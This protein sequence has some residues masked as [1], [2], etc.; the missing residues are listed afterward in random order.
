MIGI[1]DS[2]VGGLTAYREVR[3]L[4]PRADIVYLAD[5]KNAPYGTK[6]RDE[7]IK[8][9]KTDIARLRALGAT[10]ILIACCTASTVYPY[11]GEDERAR[12]LP[13]IESAAQAA[14]G[15][16]R[17]TVIATEYTVR[18]SAFGRALRER[19]ASVCVNEFPTQSLVKMVECGA[20]DGK[21]S[22]DCEGYL[23]SIAKRVR[24]FGSDGLILGCTHFSHL[25][26]TLGNLLPEVKIISPAREGA[27]KLTELARER[28]HG[29]GVDIYI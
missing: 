18:T 21:L 16:E 26:N 17:V 13:I 24:D 29:R 5:R 1:F 4:A 6:G 2:G 7:L 22:R 27:H 10:D 28:L 9:V 25:E 14:A 12:T 19:S 8:L 3:R 23:Y 11:L 20:R 15:L